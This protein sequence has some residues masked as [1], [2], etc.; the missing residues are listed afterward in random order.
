MRLVI[1]SMWKHS[2]SEYRIAALVGKSMWEA[3]FV[4][5]SLRSE[6]V[7]WIFVILFAFPPP[8]GMAFPHPL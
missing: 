6:C 1:A 5:V 4:Y 8:L 3:D 2:S 7:C